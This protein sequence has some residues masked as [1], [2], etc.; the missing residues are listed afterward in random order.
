V[1]EAAQKSKL[2]FATSDGALAPRAITGGVCYCCK[3]AIAT[4]PNN[5]VYLAW[6][7]VYPGD[8]RDIAFAASH[9]CGGRS[10]SR[11]G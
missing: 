1:T 3:T 11:S 5:A 7:H 6:R 2:Y 9:D 8:V 10:P 4:G